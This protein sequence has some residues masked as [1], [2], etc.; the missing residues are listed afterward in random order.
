MKRV[1]INLNVS[2]GLIGIQDCKNF[3]ISNM[4]E[5]NYEKCKINIHYNWGEGWGISDWC[6]VC[7]QVCLHVRV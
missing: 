3:H 6:V 5:T 2:G 1:T 4:W 7:M